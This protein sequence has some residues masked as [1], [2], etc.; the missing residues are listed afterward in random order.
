[1]FTRSLLDWLNGEPAKNIRIFLWVCAGCLVGLSSVAL[2]L[3]VC[4][5]SFALVVLSVLSAFPAAAVVTL[6]SVWDTFVGTLLFE[7]SSSS[8]D[9]EEQGPGSTLPAPGRTLDD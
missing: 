2:V 8:V 1:V 9:H 7:A 5:G 3:A 4:S 6:A